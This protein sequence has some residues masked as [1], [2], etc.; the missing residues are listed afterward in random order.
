MAST[1]AIFQQQLS[2]TNNNNGNGT[3]DGKQRKNKITDFFQ[4]KRVP[5]KQQQKEKQDLLYLAAGNV[6]AEGTT[7]YIN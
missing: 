5:Q 4:F 2:D 6:T 3:N 7:L 1:R